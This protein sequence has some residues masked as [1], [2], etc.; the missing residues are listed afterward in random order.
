MSLTR[1]GQ[2]FQAVGNLSRDPESI[3]TGSGMEIC[4]FSIP[5]SDGRKDKDTGEYGTLW[6]N[7]TAFG[8]QATKVM[9]KCT[10]G[11]ALAIE[12]VVQ[13]DTWEKDGVERAKIKIMVNGTRIVRSRDDFDG[14]GDNRNAPVSKSSV[15]DDDIPFE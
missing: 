10:K 2:S 15:K 11:T 4:N 8:D 13:L 3:T 7:C 9:E 14:S 1:T 5:V 6:L 12:G